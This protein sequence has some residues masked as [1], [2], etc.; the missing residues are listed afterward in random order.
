MSSSKET[1]RKCTVTKTKQK[2]IIISKV[3][4]FKATLMQI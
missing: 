4:V 1:H 3:A 2:D